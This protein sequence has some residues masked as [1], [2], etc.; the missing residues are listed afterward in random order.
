MGKVIKN[1]KI[2]LKIEWKKQRLLI[3]GAA[4][5]VFIGMLT[6]PLSAYALPVGD[7]PTQFSEL[8]EIVGNIISAAVPLAGIVLFV[9]LVAG[10]LQYLSSGGNPEGMQKA[11]ST[12]TYAIAGIV[13]LLL[14]WFALRFIEIFTGVPVTT[15]TV[16]S[17]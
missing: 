5:V 12:I 13:L 3:L 15:F 1:L 14:A 8:E 16:P 4:F 2:R 17:P 6:N 10:G 11:R 7:Q 9:M